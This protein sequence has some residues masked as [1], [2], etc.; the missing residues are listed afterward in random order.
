MKI[1]TPDEADKFIE[2]LRAARRCPQCGLRFFPDCKCSHINPARLSEKPSQSRPWAPKC[3]MVLPKT[4]PD[5][6]EY[7][8]P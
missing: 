3:Q 1:A 5:H 8:A 4:H 2:S 6:P 7:Q